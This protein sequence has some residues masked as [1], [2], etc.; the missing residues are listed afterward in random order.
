MLQPKKTKFRKQFKGRI[1]GAAKGGFE[2]NFGQYGL[3]AMEPERVTARQ[4]EAARRAHHASHEARRPRLDPSVPGRARLVEAD[5]SPHGQG[6]G[7]AGIL[8]LPR[9]ARP[10]HVRDRRRAGR[11]RPRGAD[12]GAPRSC[13]SRRASSSAS[14]SKEGSDEDQ[15]E[16]SDLKAMTADQL[17][18]E[19]AEAEEGTVQP[20]LPEGHRPAGERRAG[21]EVRRDIARIK[22]HGAQQAP[23]PAKA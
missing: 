9:Q 17:Q 21:Q 6:Q 5:R 1:H 3:K 20:A 11:D 13:R 2:L 15:A 19:L 18:D 14:P 22:T 23:P 16:A 4:I 10:H 12:A 7:R 8:G